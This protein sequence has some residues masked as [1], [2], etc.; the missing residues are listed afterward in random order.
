MPRLFDYW[1]KGEPLELWT[2]RLRLDALFA[3]VFFV[4]MCDRFTENPIRE[5]LGT[6]IGLVALLHALL[7]RRWYKRRWEKLTGRATRRTSWQVRDVVSLVVN[8]FLTLSFA[9]AFVSGLM[10]SQTLFAAV[11]PDAW[12]MDLTYR[13]AHV[14]L[15]LWCFLS[16]AVHAGLHAGIVAGKLAPWTKKLE[17]RIG[18]WGVR[19][20]GLVVLALLL[21]RTTVAYVVRDVPYALVAE[22]S[23]LYA[24]RGQ[25]A[26]L[27]PLDLLIAFLAVASLVYALDQTLSRRPS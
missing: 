24:A 19:I 18:L 23:Y 12:R 15:S 6:V 9:A 8:V 11:T 1:E 20:T 16:A 5:T 14:A 13:S 2:R 10:C 25:F 27:L 26:L 21:W 22:T 17:E 7:N 3:L 4:V